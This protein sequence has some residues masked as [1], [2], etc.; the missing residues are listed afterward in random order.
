[1][2]CPK[3]AKPPMPRQRHGKWRRRVA[4]K[5][6]KQQ[7]PPKLVEMLSLGTISTSQE[8]SRKW[9]C[10]ECDC[11]QWETVSETLPLFN[12]S[13]F[14]IRQFLPGKLNPAIP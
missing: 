9:Q 3:C 6:P 1:M 11:I 10:P 13:N 7:K 5:R 12:Q 8:V 2:I 14:R 4:A